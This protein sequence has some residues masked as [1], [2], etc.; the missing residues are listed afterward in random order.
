MNKEKRKEINRLYRLNNKEK[1]KQA[2]KNHYLLNR[3][4]YKNYQIEY[5]KKP[6]VKKFIKEYNS[7]KEV[8]EYRKLYNKKP[9][10][11]E[12]VRI[13]KLLNADKIKEQ[14]RIY[15]LKNKHKI[16]QYQLNNLHLNR[17]AY[18]KR[19]AAKLKA[20]P[21]FANLNKIKEIYKNCPK[22]YHVDHI[23]P[24]Q[25]KV[26]CGLHVEWNLQYLTPSE[27]S[28]KSNKLINNYL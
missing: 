22:G 6:K 21:K 1:I 26:V 28:S 23:V 10:R 8:K 20:T 2:I 13:Y 5:R 9:E 25:G 11:I 19:K 27:N 24:L 12:K 18:A 14:S 15:R 4:Y 17:A 16:K 7:S 3:E